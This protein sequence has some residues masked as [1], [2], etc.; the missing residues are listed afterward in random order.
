MLDLFL[1]DN[2]VQ[3][4][5]LTEHWLKSFEIMFNFK[6]HAVASV[7]SRQSA[8]GGGSLILVNNNVKYKNRSDIVQLSVE[9]II[10]LSCVE[11]KE[12]IV[13]CVYRPPNTDFALFDAVMC[14]VLSKLVTGKKRIV[15][16]GDFNVDLL[17]RS[18][19]QISLL[20]TFKSFNLCNL[21]LEPT[22]ITENSS[23][24]IDNIFCNCDFSSKSV[25]HCLPSD[26][27]GQMVTLT[28]ATE[29]EATTRVVRPITTHKMEMFE[30]RVGAGMMRFNFHSND[31][32]KMYSQMFKLINDVFAET[33]P[34][35]IVKKSSKLQFSDWATVGIHVSRRKLYDLYK[36]RSVNCSRDFHNYVKTYSKTFRKVCSV[37]KSLFISN[38]IK[39]SSNK[40][41]T[42]WKI[43]N[44]ETSRVRANRDK[45]ELNYQNR[46]IS[47]E[48]EVAQIFED[49]FT[50]IPVKTTC[51][52]QSSSEAAKDLLEENVGKSTSIFK[53]K[54]INDVTILK[55]FQMIKQKSTEDMWGLS[56]KIISS[57]IK[58]VACHL[59]IIFNSCVDEGIFPDLMKLSKVIPL[60]KSGDKCDSNNFRPVAIL[61]VFSKIFEKILLNQMLSHFRVNNL[62]H[63]NQYGFT[64]GRSTTDAGI[65]LIKHIFEAW[66]QSNDAIGIFCDLSKAFDCVDHR[67]LILK[68]KHYGVSDTD[69]IQSYLNSRVQ[70]VSINGVLS[71]GSKV[72][73][74]VPQG[75]ILGPF[76]FLVY[77]ND[78]PS[79]ITKHS[80]IVL[81][82]DDTSLIFK[83]KRN[84]SNTDEVNNTMALLLNWFTVNN[85]SLNAKKTNCIRF[86]LPNVKKNNIQ[87]ILGQEK[88]ELVESTKFLGITVDSRLQWGPHIE[89]LAGRLSSA[90]YAVRKI[91]ELTDVA[92]A[93]LVYFSY[94]HSIMSY[95][96]ILWGRA[97][98]V[99]SIFILQKK[100]IRAIYKLKSR[101]SLRELFKSIKIM[102]FTCQYIYENIMY[103]RK[104]LGDFP[105][106]CHE[107]NTRNKDKLLTPLLRLSKTNSSFV[108]HSIR[109]YNRL[110][111]SILLLNEKKFK[112]CIKDELI[113]KSYYKVEDYLNDKD[114]WSSYIL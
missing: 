69:L 31:P 1:Q 57:I 53:F 17:N 40:I 54:H 37:A 112:K 114:V 97:A 44:N 36:E 8:R 109:F 65:T 47:S 32:N 21:F 61:P 39:N 111:K 23:T 18:T 15:V 105:K 2:N 10:E 103:V 91:R 6:T 41:K 29:I 26:H 9:R 78:L 64:E 55:T 56:V 20:T 82:A 110:P 7:F 100:A 22:R 79:M 93:R 81:F 51:Q 74:G 30:E 108:G 45:Y 59:A 113:K 33:F 48:S 52:L 60:H 90:A 27:A 42:S 70:K 49:F 87:L 24:C 16:C 43:I 63:N 34:T 99:N 94:F 86:S 71:K 62:F 50:E 28:S 76:L 92:T 66:E 14:D 19:L 101:E 83:I 104:N 46:I 4:L 67:T 75:S 96:I 58:V 107:L 80:D 5:C 38:T 25:I 88:L 84:I 85:L 72:N 102:T 73:I 89:S 3:V 106:I 95:G 13:V 98:D 11:L 77:I 12:H 35:K 68:L